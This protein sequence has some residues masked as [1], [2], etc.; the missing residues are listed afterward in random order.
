METSASGTAAAGEAAGVADETGEVEEIG[1]GD[2]APTAAGSFDL[3]RKNPPPMTTTR[4]A[5]TV[6]TIG[7]RDIG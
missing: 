7:R 3:D 1:E 6:A 4:I 5:T 2:G